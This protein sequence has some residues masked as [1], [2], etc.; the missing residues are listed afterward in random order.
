MEIRE[1]FFALSLSLSISVLLATVGSLWAGDIR[2]P[3]Q[4]PTANADGSTPL[5]DL[6]QYR[7]HYGTVKR[8]SDNPVSFQYQS[9]VTIP[10]SQGTS[11][12]LKGLTTGQPITSPSRPLILPTTKV[13]TRQ[14][15]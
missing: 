3:W 10:A 6:N 5:K 9:S 12:T 11:H 4:A 13:N 8:S 2:I 14:M 15:K 1:R 7:V